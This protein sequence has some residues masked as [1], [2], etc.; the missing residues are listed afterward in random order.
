MIAHERYRRLRQRRDQRRERGDRRGCRTT[1][2]HMRQLEPRLHDEV[3]SLAVALTPDQRETWRDVLAWADER[4][5]YR[6]VRESA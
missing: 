4:H 3:R 5:R 2:E 6:A 1:E